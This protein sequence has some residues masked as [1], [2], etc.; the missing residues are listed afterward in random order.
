VG[1]GKE[2]KWGLSGP[3]LARSS[4]QS[5]FAI[6]IHGPSSGVQH[7]VQRTGGQLVTGKKVR[8]GGGGMCRT[9]RG[10]G[11]GGAREWKGE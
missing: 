11:E 10:R 7:R 2:G 5:F 6:V 4:R 9:H 3:F 1:L 8:E